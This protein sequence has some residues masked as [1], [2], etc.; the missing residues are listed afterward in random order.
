MNRRRNSGL[1][2]PAL[3]LGIVVAA[4]S[5]GVGTYTVIKAKKAQESE[6]NFENIDPTSPVSIAGALYGCILS[7][8]Y[9]EMPELVSMLKTYEAENPDIPEKS[10]DDEDSSESYG[11]EEQNTG[12]EEG[13]GLSV[14]VDESGVD[15]SKYLS[16][17]ANSN[18]KD[19]IIYLSNQLNSEKLI[20]ETYAFYLNSLS[21]IF[22]IYKPHSEDEQHIKDSIIAYTV[23]KNNPDYTIQ[24]VR[25]MFGPYDALNLARYLI[26]SNDY[27]RAS[28]YELR[29]FITDES[30]SLISQI[31]T[32]LNNSTMLN[33]SASD[34]V[35][36]NTNTL[37]DVIRLQ[38]G[39]PAVIAHIPMIRE[40]TPKE[41]HDSIDM[42]KSAFESTVRKSLD[43]A[44]LGK[45]YYQCIAT[46]SEPFFLTG[47]VTPVKYKNVANLDKIQLHAYKMNITQPITGCPELKNVYILAPDLRGYSDLLSRA[48]KKMSDDDRNNYHKDISLL[49]RINSGSES[50]ITL[51]LLGSDI[52]AVENHL[53]QNPEQGKFVGNTEQGILFN[54][55]L[56]SMKLLKTLEI[57]PDTRQIF[58]P[59]KMLTTKRTQAINKL[60]I[61]TDFIEVE[62]RLGKINFGML[63]YE[64]YKFMAQTRGGEVSNSELYTQPPAGTS[65]SETAAVQTETEHTD[66]VHETVETASASTDAQQSSETAGIQADTQTTETVQAENPAN[67]TEEK[68]CSDGSD[69]CVET[70]SADAPET[71]D[72]GVK[73]ETPEANVIVE[74]AHVKNPE[75]GSAEDLSNNRS[76]E[77]AARESESVETTEITSPEQQAEPERQEN[78]L[79]PEMLQEKDIATLKLLVDEKNSD[80]MYELANRYLKGHNGVKKNVKKGMSLLE[81]ACSLGNSNAQYMHGHFL[82]DDKKA[83]AADKTKGARFIIEAAESGHSDAMYQAGQL[84]YNGEYGIKRD[85]QKAFEYFSMASEQNNQDATY[86]MAK[87]YLNGEG[88]KENRQ[89]AYNLLIHTAK[90]NA[91]AAYELGLIYEGGIIDGIR[92]ERLATENF[93]FAARKGNKE[94]YRKAGLALIETKTGS[95]EALRY[96]EPY[97][98]RNDKDVDTALLNYYIK[99][100]NSREVAKFIAVAPPEIQERYPVEMGMLYETG[101]GVAQNY[102]KAEEYYR[103]GTEAKIPDAFCNL[104]DLFYYG[105][106]RDRDLRAAVGQ[107]TRGSDLGS[108]NCTEKLAFIKSTENSYRNYGE[109][110]ALISGIPDQKRSELSKALLV[111]MNLYGKGV[112]KSQTEAIKILRTMKTDGATVVRSIYEDSS[113]GNMCV[114][115]I[116][117]GTIGV[118]NKNS[119]QISIGLLSDLFFIKD[120]QANNGTLNFNEILSKTKKICKQPVISVMFDAVGNVRKPASAAPTDPEAQYRLAMSLFQDGKYEES[121]KWLKQSA[122]QDYV[123]AQNNLSIYYLFGIG[124]AQDSK[125]AHDILIK[126]VS[127]GNAKA[128]FNLAAFK[129]FG[130]GCKEDNKKALEILHTAAKMGEKAAAVQLT[131]NYLN[132]TWSSKNEDEAFE[133]LM[134]ILTDR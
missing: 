39:L 49:E 134:H 8:S 91:S 89:R 61:I 32:N 17:A 2:K 50:E 16:T 101:N 104:G 56:P 90:T 96:L 12:E 121:F 67:D 60:K 18:I 48:S 34:F 62:Q 15:I 122:D 51:T 59:T 94:A 103:K 75:P 73:E 80:A 84:L 40:E 13:F 79:T 41:N 92:D 69:S 28:G 106:G 21:N 9:D 14:S 57:S 71:A 129:M 27:E 130:I 47:I 78:L 128:H 24:D 33:L 55:N 120:Y 54:L 95:K 66:T 22:E 23:Y 4:A 97:R 109:A 98:D 111:S 110:H 52:A 88:V 114:N 31:P 112:Q 100:N 93:I 42:L 81:Q 44:E 83:S 46:T 26:G 53:E 107:Y 115:P 63:E 10:D 19:K 125:A 86:M 37:K 3:L 29:R 30:K 85:L 72:A 123:K 132:G 105:K 70:A 118:K 20:P 131:Y 38:K 87:M 7:D 116:L 77:E 35:G 124:T 133:A 117:A 99:M 108:V 76:V 25:S 102:A 64:P 43:F 1:S 82:L 45:K 127:R 119:I 11:Y 36:F 126:A 68:S 6:N 65:G 74:T 5:V 113:K 58:A